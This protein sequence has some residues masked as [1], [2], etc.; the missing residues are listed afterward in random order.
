MLPMVALYGWCTNPGAPHLAS[1]MWVYPRQERRAKPNG[2]A[3]LSFIPPTLQNCRALIR[4]NDFI[5]SCPKAASPL[6]PNIKWPKKHLRDHKPRGI[7]MQRVEEKVGGLRNDRTGYSQQ[8][9][10]T[11]AKPGRAQSLASLPRSRANPRPRA[12]SEIEATAISGPST[13]SKVTFGGMSF[14][15]VCTQTSSS[16]EAGLSER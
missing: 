13:L 6:Q 16:A 14:A 12:S 2:S 15:A 8:Q 1:E 4:T 7:H 11:L 9:R 10:L 3:L 5:S